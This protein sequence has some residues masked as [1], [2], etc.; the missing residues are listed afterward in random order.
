[1]GQSSITCYDIHFNYPRGKFNYFLAERGLFS[2]TDFTEHA[3]VVMKVLWSWGFNIRG[4]Y[5]FTNNSLTIFWL[6]LCHLSCHQN[7]AF[8]STLSTDSEAKLETFNACYYATLCFLLQ[9]NLL[10]VEPIGSQLKYGIF[11]RMAQPR[12]ACWNLNLL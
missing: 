5:S 7:F 10:V 2:W 12:A 4:A 3:N 9:V 11:S 6:K 1:M 8:V